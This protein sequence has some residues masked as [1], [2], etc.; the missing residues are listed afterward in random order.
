MA[1]LDVYIAYGDDDL[2]AKAQSLWEDL[3]SE[4]ARPAE[5]ASG[6]VHNP[7]FLTD[8]HGGERYPFEM[9]LRAE[10]A[11]SFSPWSNVAIQCE[12]LACINE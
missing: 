8:C 6:R 5:I 4:L 3:A 12:S 11:R 10:L 9:N 7:T 1:C 2:L